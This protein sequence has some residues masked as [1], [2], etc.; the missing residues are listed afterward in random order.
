V[1]ITIGGLS[2]LGAA[3]LFLPGLLVRSLAVAMVF[4]VAAGIMFGSRDPPLDAARLDVM[5]HRLWGRA[6]S[7]R[8][9]LRRTM[10]ASSAIVFGNL[11]DRLGRGRP[12]EGVHGFGAHARA[13][14]MRMT[15]LILLV[16]LFGGG[17][18][19][20]WARRTYPRDVSTTLA[21]EEATAAAA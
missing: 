6:E 19:T 21:S 3:L 14:G 10:V 15:F 9:V 13:Y 4:Y 12:L 7:V 1:R 2:Y 17:V 5:H 8:T 16:S 11:A 18:L 20:L